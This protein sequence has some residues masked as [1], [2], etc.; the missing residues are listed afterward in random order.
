M[1]VL[2]VE[3]DP[4]QR[5]IIA[6][7]LTARG[8][9]V[10]SVESGEAA[11]ELVTS[12]NQHFDSI[13]MDQHMPG[14]GGVEATRRIRTLGDYRGQVSILAMSAGK[15]PTEP[16]F[17]G[18]LPKD[19]ASMDA[20][21]ARLREAVTEAA[22]A[23][24]A[25]II[26]DQQPPR[27]TLVNWMKLNLVFLFGLLIAF[28]GSAVGGIWAVSAWNSDLRHD[29]ADLKKLVASQ[30]AQIEEEH[31]AMVD[32]DRRLND[33]RRD[34]EAN[35]AAARRETDA[36]LVAARRETDAN[37]AK[38]NADVAVLKAQFEFLA[39]RSPKAPLPGAP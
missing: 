10:M 33:A 34:T 9:S 31:K 20:S 19:P 29:A 17:D 32:V 7:T 35:L 16:G 37:L 14:I 8:D 22:A 36:N 5:G 27:S 25:R 28:V 18:F 3:D 4:V 1:K 21:M 12:G 24:Q 11:V 39:A 38:A 6:A 15:A 13:L 2:V 23:G 30:G 26:A